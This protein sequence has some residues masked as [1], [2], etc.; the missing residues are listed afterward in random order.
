MCW[1]WV[2]QC[3]ITYLRTNSEILKLDL[4]NICAGGTLQDLC[5]TLNSSSSYLLLGLVE[6][7][8]S[9]VFVF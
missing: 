1:Q 8:F 9:F 3:A 6:H 7:S 5:K 2:L 4:E